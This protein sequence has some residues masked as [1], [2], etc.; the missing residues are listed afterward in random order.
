[1]LSLPVDC[2]IFNIAK[3]LATT[4]AIVAWSHP[5]S[6]LH[7][8]YFHFAVT[9]LTLT[10]ALS[11]AGTSSTAASPCGCSYHCLCHWLIVSF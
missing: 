7:S 3:S 10:A 9:L 8:K 4:T 6:L 1:M 11:N 5:G 2:C